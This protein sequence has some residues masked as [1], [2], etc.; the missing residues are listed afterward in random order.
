[1]TGL[2]PVGLS[3]AAISD[4]SQQNG[5]C[6]TSGG[7]SACIYPAIGFIN[8]EQPVLNFYLKARINGEDRILVTNIDELESLQVVRAFCSRKTYLIYSSIVSFLALTSQVSLAMGL[9]SL[10][11]V[12]A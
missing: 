10:A 8:K 2:R 12:P 11:S 6:T 3:D 9:L 4:L 1:M 7:E 5:F